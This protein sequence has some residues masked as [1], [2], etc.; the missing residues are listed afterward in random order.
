MGYRD[1]FYCMRNL[2]GYTGQIHHFPT[3]YFVKQT[4]AGAFYGHITQKHDLPGNVGRMEVRGPDPRYR[5]GN[6][7]WFRKHLVESSGGRSFHTSRGRLVSRQ[8]MKDVEL[9][10]CLLAIRTC[11]HEKYI[12][13]Y[14]LGDRATILRQMRLHNHVITPAALALQKQRI[15]ANA[16]QRHQFHLAL[17]EAEWALRRR[18]L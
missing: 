6:E 14:S 5:A 1:D 16:P 7:G 17:D 10:L 3:I 4:P 15:H 18:G 8:E 2:F 11:P 13:A 12:T 9:A